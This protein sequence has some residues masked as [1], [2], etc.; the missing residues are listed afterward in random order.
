MN[1]TTWEPVWWEPVLDPNADLWL[2]LRLYNLSDPSAVTAARLY[3]NSHQ[4]PVTVQD[5][6]VRIH[7]TPEQVATVPR[8]AD[9]KLYV[10]LAGTG[11]VLWLSG[12]VSGGGTHDE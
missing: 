11:T 3:M 7:L 6:H 5:S 9:A 1:L 4:Y 8:G 12:K 2:T 10:D